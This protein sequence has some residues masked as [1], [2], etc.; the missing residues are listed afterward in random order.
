MEECVVGTIVFDIVCMKR[1][2]L[3]CL[4]CSLGGVFLI[5]GLGACT[6]VESLLFFELMP[7]VASHD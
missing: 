2:C 7:L 5:Y 6:R 3:V 4:W 1:A